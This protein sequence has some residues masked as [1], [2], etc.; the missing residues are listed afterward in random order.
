MK[1]M[2]DENN[3]NN[4]TTTP[5]IMLVDDEPITLEMIQ[6]YLEKAGYAK[7]VSVSDSTKALEILEETNPDILLLDLIKPQVSGFDILAELRKK[8][9]FKYLPIIILTASGAP[10]DKIKALDLGAT[11][12]LAKPVDPTELA[13][14][15]FV[16][17]QLPRLI[18]ITSHFMI[19]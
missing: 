3:S 5:V 14:R 19:P 18:R 13:L 10:E 8:T 9:K 15:A 16:I 1:I 4:D 12:F 7:F 6:T 2:P 11:D 17:L